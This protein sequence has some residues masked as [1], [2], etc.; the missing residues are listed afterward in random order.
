MTNFNSD[1][2]IKNMDIAIQSLSDDVEHNVRRALLNNC[3]YVFKYELGSAYQ[4]CLQ[5]AY[6]FLG[7]YNEKALEDLFNKL[8]ETHLI[9]RREV[10]DLIV[11]TAIELEVEAFELQEENRVFG[12]E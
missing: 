1:E 3:A 2:T 6:Q 7:Y 9:P 5:Q 11:Q 4:C 10:E 8:N 12:D